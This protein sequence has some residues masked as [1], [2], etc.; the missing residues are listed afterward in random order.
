MPADFALSA[1][2]APASK[3]V[4]VVGGG[5]SG[6][7]CAWLLS[8]SHH[9]TLFESETRLGGHTRTVDVCVDGRRFPVDTGFL[10]FNDR[11][12]PNLCALFEHLGVRSVASDMSFSVRIDEASIEWSGATLAS[13]F[14]QRRNL[15]NVEFWGMLKDILRFNRET[16]RLVDGGA[17]VSGTLAAFLD[18]GGFGRAFRD[19]YLLPMG[20]AIWSC[21][22]ARMLD[23]P[24]ATFLRFCRNH[25]LLQIDDRPRWRTVVGGGREYVRR[26]ATALPDIRLG[27]RVFGIERFS[28]HVT[29]ESPCG[30]EGFDDVVLATHADTTLR[31]LRDPSRD[32]SA[33]LAAVGYQPNRAVLHMDRSFL[34][35]R[36]DAWSAW[37]YHSGPSRADGRP[38][39]V[40]YLLNR[41]QPLPVATPVLVTLNPIREPAPAAV[42]GECEFSH[43][44]FDAHA[45]AAQGLLESIQGRR[46][47]WYCGAW[48]GNGFHEDGLR[49]AIVVARAL[50]VEVPWLRETAAA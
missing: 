32:E 10:V 17:H 38:V 41:L 2:G 50:G 31:M 18:R 4:A 44:V 45:I 43:P 11:T 16:S 15:L 19:W 6:L 26:L 46:R 42:L 24:A 1:G 8:R 25:G 47:T 20:A 49:S 14:A 37:N 3:R 36:R 27:A 23:H 39:S 9:V 30:R 40:T 34:P 28:R 33:L 7:A 12:Y 35:H 13:V 22:T 29:V 5:I 21:P 48:T